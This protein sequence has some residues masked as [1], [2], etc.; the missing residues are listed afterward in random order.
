MASRTLAFLAYLLALT[1]RPALATDPTLPADRPQPVL[2]LHTFSDPLA[3]LMCQRK[4]Y[5]YFLK[6]GQD[7]Y[8]CLMDKA[9]PEARAVETINR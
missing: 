6:L 5:P 4:G 3:A 2:N 7:R 1:D 9:S 8:V